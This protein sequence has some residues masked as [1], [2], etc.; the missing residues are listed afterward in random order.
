VRVPVNH[1]LGDENKGFV[2][3]M[4][5]FDFSRSLIGLQ[6]LAVARVALEETWEYITQRQAFG[7]PLSAF[8]GVTHPLAAFD[9]E[10][11]GRPPALPAGPVAEG[12]WPAAHRRGRHGQVVG[13][14]A[15]L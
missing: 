7:Q 8:Q 3:V 13:A 14:K 9:T 11:E 6:C 2:Q 10:V 1:R 5:G 4:Q 15:G 12:P